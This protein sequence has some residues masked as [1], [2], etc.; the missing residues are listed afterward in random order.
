[1]ATAAQGTPMKNLIFIILFLL[2]SSC[3]HAATP[4]R[5]RAAAP[6]NSRRLMSATLESIVLANTSISERGERVR[7][8]RHDQCLN[9]VNKRRTQSEHNES[10]CALTADIQADIDLCRGVRQRTHAPQAAYW[11]RP[12]ALT[13]LAHLSASVMYSFANSSGPIGIGKK[14]CA[15]KAF[16]VSGVV[17][18]FSSA[19]ASL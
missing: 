1:M 4:P 19:C 6:L 8:L 11:L 13:T 3:G 5:R 9:R 16:L 17:S 12:S 18:V 14:P 10:A 2:C 15:S 7:H